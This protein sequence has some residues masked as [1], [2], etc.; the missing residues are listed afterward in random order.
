MDDELTRNESAQEPDT[1]EAVIEV[2]DDRLVARNLGSGQEHVLDPGPN[3]HSALDN[4]W[5][6]LVQ[7]MEERRKSAADSEE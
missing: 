4:L 2:V 1:F 3:A 5:R 7:G 6:T